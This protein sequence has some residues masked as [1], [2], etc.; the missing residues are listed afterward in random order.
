MMIYNSSIEITTISEGLIMKKPIVAIMYDFDKTL[1]DKDMQ[2]YSFIPSL[3]MTPSEFW[4]Q[5]D[6]LAKRCNMDHILAYMMLMVTKSKEKGIPLTRQ[7][8]FEQGKTVKLND[9][10]EQWFD[11]INQYGNKLGLEV[12]HYIISCGLKPMIEGCPIGDRFH[13]IYACDYVYDDNGV[14]L[15]PAIAINYTSKTQF[16]FRINKGIED[17]SEHKR[18]NM[19]TPQSKRAVKYSN[20]VYVGDGLTDV[21]AMKMSRDRGGYSIGVYE[22]REDAQYL[23]DQ[24]RVDFYV[25][26]DYTEGSE[27]HKVMTSVLDKIAATETISSLSSC[28]KKK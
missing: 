19:Y 20:M 16:L 17:V 7:T 27:M 8:L 12:R 24:D 25:K 4:Q 3:S 5:S 23:I 6:E 15:W 2:E 11:L 14:P 22:N 26:A 18:L 28:L 21:P 10:V 13:Q 9:G 1:S